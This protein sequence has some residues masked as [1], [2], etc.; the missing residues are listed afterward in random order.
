MCLFIYL[1][2]LF[3]FNKNLNKNFIYIYTTYRLFHL[4][5]AFH[6]GEKRKSLQAGIETRL[7]LRQTDN[8]FLS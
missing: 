1:I 3:I 7:S 4:I 2:I 5:T 8:I 6:C